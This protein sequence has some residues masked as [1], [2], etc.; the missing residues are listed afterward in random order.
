MPFTFRRLAIPDVV[1]IEPRAFEDERGYF[2]ELFKQTEF[3]D[4]GLSCKIVQQNLSHSVKGVLR[5]L[6]Y[7][8]RPREQAKLVTAVRGDV[9]DVAVDIRKSS[10]YFGKYVAENLSGRNH[11]MLYVPEGFAHG[12]CVLSDEAEV[13]YAVTKEYSRAH[14]RGIVWSDSSI[15]VEWPLSKPVLSEKDMALPTL[16]NADNN[17]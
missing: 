9:Y 3:A 15:G 7:Q 13:S 2:V 10:P 8:L 16:E 6:H 12:F 1:L 14:E 17:F 4:F 5:G 11:R